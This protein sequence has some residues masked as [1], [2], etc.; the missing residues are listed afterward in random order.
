PLTAGFNY[1]STSDST[2]LMRVMIDPADRINITLYN[3]SVTDGVIELKEM[4]SMEN[5][6]HPDLNELGIWRMYSTGGNLNLTEMACYNGTVRPGTP[7]PVDSATPVVKTSINNTSPK[8][9]EII[10]I[11]ANITDDI[12]LSFCQV[13]ENQTGINMIT[14]FSITTP[15]E[16]SQAITITV[17]K[18]NVIN[19]TVRANDTSNNFHTNDSQIITVIN[20]V[21]VPTIILP[22]PNDFNNTIP[23]PFNVTF[24]QDGDGD[25]ITINYYVNGKLNDTTALNTTFNGSDSTYILNVSLF[26]GFDH[27]VN[28]SVTFTIDTTFPTLLLF[29]L[30]NNTIFGFNANA[31]MNITMQDTNPFL[32]QFNWHNASLSE[33]YNVSNNTIQS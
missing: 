12:Q 1:L 8:I 27:S 16:C 33:I 26:D 3:F 10:N 25:S 2:Y 11:T 20:S 31:T 4:T 19:F 13:I 6:S 32:L 30:T 28:V 29:N 23:Y 7:P 18:G 24:D 14:N 9:N 5:T 21:P 17:G 15:A 22:T